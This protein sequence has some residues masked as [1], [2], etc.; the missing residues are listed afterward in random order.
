MMDVS[1]LRIRADKGL[2][3]VSLKLPFATSFI[4]QTLTKK[5]KL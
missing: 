5:L 4:R 3:Y 1:R 2:R